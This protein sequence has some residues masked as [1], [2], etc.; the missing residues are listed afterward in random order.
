MG[1]G[2]ERDVLRPVRCTHTRSLPWAEAD[3]NYPELPFI[4]DEERGVP[5]LRTEKVD[6]L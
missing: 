1:E 4:F 3:V 6:F 2:F 5:S